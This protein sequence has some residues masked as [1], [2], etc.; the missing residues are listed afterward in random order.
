M[1]KLQLR[2]ARELFFFNSSQDLSFSKNSPR[3]KN[4]FG[5]VVRESIQVESIV[6]GMVMASPL[7]L[8]PMPVVLLARLVA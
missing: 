7:I 4:K 2:H 6:Q 8:A 3:S 5:D 1:V